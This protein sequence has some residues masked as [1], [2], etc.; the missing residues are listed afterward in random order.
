MRILQITPQAPDTNS[1]GTIGVLQ[2]ALSLLENGYDVDY[3]GPE[4]SNDSIRKHYSNIYEL[5]A[6]NNKLML[7]YDAVRGITNRRYRAWCNLEVD[8]DVYDAVVIDFTKLD[9]VLS[10]LKRQKLYVRVHNVEFDYENVNYSNN[11]C[12]KNWILKNTILKK[13]RKIVSDAGKLVFLTEADRDRMRNLYGEFILDKSEIVPVCVNR[14]IITDGLRDASPINLLIT[15]SLWFGENYNGVLW[16]LEEVCPLIKSEY[17]LTIAGAHPTSELKN[18]ISNNHHVVL[19]DTPKKM[20][21]LF[22]ATDIVVAPVFNGA[23]MKVKVAEALSYAKPI[24]GTNHAFIGYK[25]I[26]GCNSYI[27]DD[28]Q[29]FANAIDNYSKLS[30]HDKTQMRS[31]IIDLFNSSYCMTVS[32]H[33]WK[34]ILEPQES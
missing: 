34:E 24:V 28:A 2:T 27:A 13:E 15:G 21:P 29:S 20:D 7:I 23:G 18:V 11:K 30:I 5:E 26:S 19:H 8:F 3:I 16:F 33:I 17:K 1:G 10:R 12:L 32:S 9:Y 22:R 6:T 14:R 25:I 4:I 31:E